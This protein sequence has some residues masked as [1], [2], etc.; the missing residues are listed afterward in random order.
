MSEIARLNGSS[1]AIELDF[2]EREDTLTPRYS[3]N[4]FKF[5][6]VNNFYSYHHRNVSL[7]VLKKIDIVKIS[8]CSEYRSSFN[9]LWASPYNKPTS[10]GIVNN[11]HVRNRLI[12]DATK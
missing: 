8:N 11:T 12:F 9:D 2:V 1:D 4:G 5:K 10:V 6:S 3:S 7:H